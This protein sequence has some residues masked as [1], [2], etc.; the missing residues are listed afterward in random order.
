M[1]SGRAGLGTVAALVGA[2]LAFAFQQTAIVPAIPA[3]QHDLHASQEWSAWLLTGYLVASSVATPLLGKLGDRHG[4]R[5]A[6]IA[7][8]VGYLLASV[9]AALSPGI[10]PLIAF[11]SLQGLGGA[12][13]PLTLSLARDLLPPEQLGR[14]VGMLTGSFGAGTAAGFGVSG[15]VVEALSWRWLFG[16]GA[17]VV[18][19]ATVGLWRAAEVREQTRPGRLDLPGTLLLAGGL[20]LELIAL[21]EGVS[22]GFSSP[23]VLGGFAVGTLLLAGWAVVDLRVDDPLLDLKVLAEPAVL[24]TNVTTLALGYVLFGTY[25]LVPYLLENPGGHGVS[26]GPVGAGL[27]LLPSAAGQAIAGPLAGRLS[28]RLAPK[29]IVGGGMTALAAASGLLAEWHDRPWQLAVWLFLLG[30]GAGAALSVISDLVTSLVDQTE[31]G[32]AA[33][34]NSTLRRFSGGV[35]SQI[36]ALLLATLTVHPHVAAGRAFVVAFGI[37]GGAAAAGA[38]TSLAI[39]RRE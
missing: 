21:T 37:G 33:S 12:I 23:L 3:V 4:R 31:S 38:G 15:F 7:S 18:A 10:V 24:L 27:Y 36:D 6:L 13:F 20:S 19:V 39:R 29:W 1:G 5:R 14:A 34:L 8:L 9:G 16:F 22:R 26:A 11:R 35:G 30:A 2:D 17:F 32:A 28:G 25:F